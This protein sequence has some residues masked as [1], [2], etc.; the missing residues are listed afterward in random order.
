MI[1]TVDVSILSIRKMIE[2]YFKEKAQ[3][4]KTYSVKAVEFETRSTR[5]KGDLGQDLPTRRR[6]PDFKV[7][8]IHRYG[9]A[10]I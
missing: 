8:G 7:A 4:L 1:E 9:E 6:T 5:H 2:Y 3:A 10:P